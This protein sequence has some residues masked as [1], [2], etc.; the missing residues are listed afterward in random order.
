SSSTDYNPLDYVTLGQY[1]GVAVELNKADYEVTDE[2][3]YSKMQEL[4]GLNIV[5]EADP[6]KDVV[7]KDC[8]VNVDYVGKLN[9]EA[10]QGGSASN[11]WIDVA[12][13]ADAEKGTKY[14]DGFSNGVVG[15]RVGTSAE[16]N[17]TFPENYGS[18]N[19]AGKE[20]TFEFTIN[21]IAKDAKR[22]FTDEYVQQN[23]SY[24]SV[25]ALKAEAKTQLE[26][27]LAQKKTS[28]TTQK[29]TEAVLANCK[30]N[31]LP[32]AAV[33]ARIDEY[34]KYYEQRYASAE[35]GK[36][37]E[38]V[39]QSNYGM[40]LDEFKQQVRSEFEEEFKTQLVFEAIAA[41][42]KMTVDEDGFN[43]FVNEMVSKNGFNSTDTLYQYYGSGDA[44]S[45]E[46]YL[47]TNYLCNKALEYCVSKASVTEK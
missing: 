35:S 26:T 10:F 34:M 45:G 28:D 9:G 22:E 31:S 18:A 1:E 19:L 25:D 36:T 6:N 4:C 11:V 38:Q 20:V 40:S 7:T 16:Y 3:L 27:E 15:A 5:Y 29:V 8:V 46:K 24:A 30:V 39:I 37:F 32:E 2:N 42:Q 12:K 41:D 47:R 43:K 21:S 23:S 17:V 13:N 14:I 44:K 33:N